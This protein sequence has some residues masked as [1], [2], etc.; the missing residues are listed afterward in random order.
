MGFVV[1]CSAAPAPIET[2]A[3]VVAYVTG[4]EQANISTYE[5]G[6]SFSF[7][8]VVALS[9]SFSFVVGYACSDVSAFRL[10]MN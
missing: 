1:S 5:P 3:C 9:F 7:S 4:P 6:L 10:A 2:V 8:A